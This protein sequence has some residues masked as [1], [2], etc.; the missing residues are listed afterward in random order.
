MTMYNRLSG[1]LTAVLL[2]ACSADS[3]LGV[4]TPGAAGD[5]EE[6][7]QVAAGW[8][9]TP[10]VTATR[11][12]VEAIPFEDYEISDANPLKTAV[13]FSTTKSGSDFVFKAAD[14]TFTYRGTDKFRNVARFVNNKPHFLIND[15]SYPDDDSEI[16]AV[17]LYP[18]NVSSVSA[19]HA[20]DYDFSGNCDWTTSDGK[21]VTHAIDGISDL[22]VTNRMVAKKS[23]KYCTDGEYVAKR[24]HFDHLLTRL[25]VMVAA[26]SNEAITS[27]GPITTLTL[28]NTVSQVQVNLNL[29]PSNPSRVTYSGSQDLIAF[30]GSYA[31]KPTMQQIGHLMVGAPVLVSGSTYKYELTVQSENMTSAKSVTATFTLPS[32][33][34]FAGDVLVLSLSFFERLR[35]EANCTLEPM[36]D[37]E[38]Y[39]FGN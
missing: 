38:E 33:G 11:A 31:L 9:A 26:N 39:I 15:V 1:I 27:W 23:D 32:D 7:I 5:S 34:N 12:A 4:N 35:V 14:G 13:W 19:A 10:T 22:M 37:S 16:A 18:H 3:D 25:K 20:A 21:I 17:G 29:D 8:G 36:T 28:K 30:D 24:L 2:T 6:K